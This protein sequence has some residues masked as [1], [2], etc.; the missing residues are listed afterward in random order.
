MRITIIALF[1]TCLL[2]AC[3]R[4]ENTVTSVPDLGAVRANLAF[5]CMHEAAHLPQIDQE[6]ERLFQ[7]ARYLEKKEGPKDY[8]DIAR[9]YRIAAAYGNFKA[10]HNLQLLVSTG[11]ASSPDAEN[12]SVDLAEQLIKAGVPSGYY[13]VGHYLL[14]GYGL[15]QDAD[16]A[17]SYIRKA[18]DLGNADAQYYVANLLDPADAAPDIAL[19]MFQCAADQGHAEAAN[20]LGTKLQDNEK[21]ADAMVAFQKSA[22]A[23]N[24]QGAFALE[25]GFLAKSKSDVV[26]YLGVAPDP[27]RATRYKLIGKFID[28]NDGRNPRVPD[29]DKIVPLPPAKLPPWDGTFEWQKQQDAA[30]P[31]QKPSEELIDRL[32]KTKQLDPATGLPLSGLLKKTSQAEEPVS[33]ASRVPLGTFVSTGEICPEDGVWHAKLQVGQMGD[34]QRRFLKGDTLPSLVVHESRQLALLDRVMGERR[35]T[36]RVAWELVAYIDQV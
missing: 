30:T 24:T 21:Y 25:M 14:N 27:E 15:K 13:D 11:M 23:G 31:P 28:G 35:Q 33:V 4:N 5:T 32:A 20:Y 17:R 3:S 16:A 36:S 8:N 19:Q 7:Y 2:C 10:N 26:S 29:I 1:A 18:A 12:E 34:S 22:A 9:Y 6:S